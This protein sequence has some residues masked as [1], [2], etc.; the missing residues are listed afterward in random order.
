LPS[1]RTVPARASAVPGGPRRDRGSFP[2]RRSGSTRAPAPRPGG[3]GPPRPPGRSKPPAGR[4]SGIRARRRLSGSG[5]RF[6]GAPGR[7]P[8]GIPRRPAGAGLS[9]EEPAHAGE[10]I[11]PAPLPRRQ[12]GSCAWACPS[13]TPPVSPFRSGNYRKN[14]CTAYGGTELSLERGMQV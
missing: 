7:G 14:P 9:G 2:A 1:R 3:P 5:R 13:V 8:P 12:A 11:A 6:R 10:A 4:D